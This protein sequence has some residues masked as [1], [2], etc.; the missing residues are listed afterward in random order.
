[1]RKVFTPQLQIPNLR[2][3]PSRKTVRILIRFR[4]LGGQ[5]QIPTRRVADQTQIR[6]SETDLIKST[7]DVTV[8]RVKLLRFQGVSNGERMD[9]SVW[10]PFRLRLETNNWIQ[11]RRCTVSRLLRNS[12]CMFLPQA[13]LLR[14]PRSQSTTVEM[15]TC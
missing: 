14:E 1:M 10:L 4:G 7:F 8:R 9:E 6:D 12:D 5:P 15:K 11:T 2:S 13:L 3:N